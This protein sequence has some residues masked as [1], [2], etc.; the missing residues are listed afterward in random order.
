MEKLPLLLNWKLPN[1]TRMFFLSSYIDV[2]NNCRYYSMGWL[3]VGQQE[4][5]GPLIIYCSVMGTRHSEYL[6]RVRRKFRW[7]SMIMFH[8][9][10]FSM[11][12]ILYIY[13]MIRWHSMFFVLSLPNFFQ[14][15]KLI[16]SNIYAV[17]RSSSRLIE[18]LQC[19]TLISRRLLWCLGW[20]P[21]TFI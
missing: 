12:R 9:R 16:P 14:M 10:T 19:A 11:T 3:I 1:K 4:L 13:L 6:K 8:T 17:W 15:S 21:T 20:R 5:L 18:G 2:S 7:S